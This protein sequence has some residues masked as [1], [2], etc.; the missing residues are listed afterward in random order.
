MHANLFANTY[1]DENPL[2]VEIV[3]LSIT[4]SHA[5]N[6]M[7]GNDKISVFGQ[8]EDL[9]LIRN[10]IAVYLHDLAQAVADKEAERY[11]EAMLDMAIERE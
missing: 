10:T 6:I 9:E 5:L 4:N 7:Q 8:I 2:K 1:A 3:T 11:A